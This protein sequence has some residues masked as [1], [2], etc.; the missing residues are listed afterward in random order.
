MNVFLWI[1]QGLLAATFAAAG[2]LKSTRSREQLIPQ[3]PWVSDVSTPVVRLIGAVEFAGAL[4]LILP[5]AFDIATVLTPLAATGLAVI[6]V[7]AMGLHARR[8]EPA[9]IA[10]NAVL[11]ILTAVVMWGR[12]GPHAL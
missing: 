10:F 3:L 8:K 5:G 12:F 4:G 1:A 6:M 9:A 2:V 7:L 11:L